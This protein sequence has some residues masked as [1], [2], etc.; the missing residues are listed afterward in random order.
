MASF[1]H[2]L[3]QRNFENL[4]S[5]N[6]KSKEFETEL[7][8]LKD[9]KSPEKS[10]EEIQSDFSLWLRKQ[11]N[12]TRLPGLIPTKPQRRQEWLE[13]YGEFKSEPSEPSRYLEIHEDTHMYQFINTYV[14]LIEKNNLPLEKIYPITVGC[15]SLVVCGTG[16]GQFI[17]YLIDTL[18]PYSLIIAVNDWSEFVSSF[19]YVDWIEIWNRFSSEDKIIQILKVNDKTEI[20]AKV[21]E[22][23]LL[24]LE[25]AYVYIDSNASAELKSSAKILSSDLVSHTINYLGYTVDEYNMIVNTFRTLYREPKTYLT[26]RLPAKGRAI[27]CASGPSLDSDIDIIKTLSI[28]SA[29]IASASSIRTLLRNGIRVDALVLIER[30]F[31]VYEAYKDLADEF[32]LSEIILFTSTTCDCNLSSLFNKRVCFF[33]SALTPLAVFSDTV[34]ELLPNDGPEAVNA[35]TSLACTLAFDEINFFGVDLG[36][37]DTKLERSKDAVAFTY[38]TWDMEREGNKDKT[39]HTNQAMLDVQTVLE[40]TIQM[41]PK[42]SYY[43]WSDGLKL[44]GATSILSLN[45]YQEITS[46]KPMLTNNNLNMLDDYFN[47]LPSYSAARVKSSWEAK[48]LRQTTYEVCDKLKNLILSDVDWFPDMLINLEKIMSIQCNLERQFPRRILRGSIYKSFLLVT[49]TLFV[50]KGLSLEIQRTVLKESKDLLLKLVKRL[51]LEIYMVCDFVEN[52]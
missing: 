33:R 34:R 40:R 21:T 15:N 51:E 27:V 25:F 23:S 16:D 13:L 18:K 26:P 19:H 3:F 46:V 8:K 41:Y 29:V 6:P 28:D 36:S 48:N 22:P 31:D 35:A 52:E 43:N 50:S 24:S 9:Y 11:N 32:D 14:Q 7:Y 39:I 44:Q 5:I 49:Q 12:I 42:I 10:L 47:R 37:S 30:G 17:K 20:L 45:K 38:R 1:F 2:M 4:V